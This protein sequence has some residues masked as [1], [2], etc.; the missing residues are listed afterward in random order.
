MPRRL[1]R[2]GAAVMSGL[3]AG[4]ALSP[5]AAAQTPAA[6][7]AQSCANDANYRKFDFWIG[8]WD[9]QRTGVPRAPIGTGASSTVERIL[10]GCVILE[11]WTPL[12]GPA[13]KSFNIYN[14]TTKKWEQYWVNAAGNITHYI[15]EFRDDGNL[16]YEADQFGNPTTKV[17]MTFFNQGPTQVRQLG[18]Q[19]TDGGK[20][21]TVTFDLTYVRK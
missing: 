2:Q 18:H 12:K 17:R 19:S 4:A 8:D 9:V 1:I 11:N 6:P 21:W 3:L 15:G 13:G 20:T 5:T 7:P 10:D 14:R 16:Y